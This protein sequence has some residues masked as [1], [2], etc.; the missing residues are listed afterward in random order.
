MNPAECTLSREYEFGTGI[1]AQFKLAV[2]SHY[3]YIFSNGRSALLVDPGR[4]LEAYLAY[5]E[6]HPLQHLLRLLA[7]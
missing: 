5:L 1:L 4:E 3:S 6:L 2:L 7:R